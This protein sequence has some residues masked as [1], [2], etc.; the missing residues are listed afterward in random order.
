[1]NAI[2]RIQKTNL[3]ELRMVWSTSRTPWSS[4]KTGGEKQKK[5]SGQKG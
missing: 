5:V 1:M 2:A 3:A 4:W